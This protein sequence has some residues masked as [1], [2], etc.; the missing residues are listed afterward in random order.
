MSRTNHLVILGA[1]RSG[2]TMLYGVLDMHPDIFMA[3]P[4]KPEPKYFLNPNATYE[5]YLAEVFPTVSN[6]VQYLGEKSTSYYESPQAIEQML[7]VI[8]DVKL[9]IM[10]RNPVQRALSN[11]FFSRQHGLE[12]RTLEEVFLKQLPAP[13]YPSSISVNPFDYLGRS[14][15]ANLL[16]PYFANCRDQLCI[17]RFEHFIAGEE[18]ARLFDFLNLDVPSVN[19]DFTAETHRNE[20]QKKSVSSELLAF[21][22][23]F[24]RSKIE[25]LEGLIALNLNRWK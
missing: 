13:D 8:P 21:L 20:S 6:S 19:F 16:K 23:E 11:Y 15:Y 22:N 18:N 17:L 14:D 5:S 2:T 9:L 24:Y 7:Q 4:V 3:K 25:A 10:L 12:T 1:Q